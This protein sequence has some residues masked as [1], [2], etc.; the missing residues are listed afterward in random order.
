MRT[1]SFGKTMEFIIFA[2]AVL[3]AMAS[4]T[5]FDNYQLN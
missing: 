2:A 5:C 1:K 3:K 4:E